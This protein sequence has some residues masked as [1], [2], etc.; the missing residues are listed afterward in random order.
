[1]K[2]KEAIEALSAGDVPRDDTDFW[3]ELWRIKTTTEEVR[4]R[5]IDRVGRE[6]MCVCVCVGGWVGACVCAC[7]REGGTSRAIARANAIN[8]QQK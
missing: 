2:F 7:G 1:M 6:R 3:D 8:P 5:E 4:V